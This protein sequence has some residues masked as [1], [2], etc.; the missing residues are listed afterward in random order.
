MMKGKNRL[1]QD[2][3]SFLCTDDCNA[4]ACV[5]QNKRIITILQILATTPNFLQLKVLK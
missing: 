2:Y 5:R 3:K 4:S 1:G